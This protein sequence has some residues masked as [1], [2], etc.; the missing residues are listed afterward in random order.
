MDSIYLYG[1]SLHHNKRVQ[2]EP[3]D[4]LKKIISLGNENIEYSVEIDGKNE[5]RNILIDRNGDQG[6][7]FG[8][9]C[10]QNGRFS[11]PRWVKCL[12]SELKLVS[13]LI[14]NVY[15]EDLVEARKRIWP[16]GIPEN[17]PKC[18]YDSSNCLPG[19]ELELVEFSIILVC[20]V[21]CAI[22]IFGV[23][24]AFLRYSSISGS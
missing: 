15:P 7:R 18:G 4:F 5:I 6:L 14:E 1:Y 21:L 20:S 23:I 12:E 3:K 22:L 10:I 17:K 2:G 11:T 8:L 24:L 19:T 9:Y 16:N 13:G